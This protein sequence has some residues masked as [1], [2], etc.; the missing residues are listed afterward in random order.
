MEQVRP[1]PRPGAAPEVRVFLKPENPPLASSP[2]LLLDNP[3]G[4]KY[5]LGK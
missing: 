1:I 4:S 2:A 5:V 3:A